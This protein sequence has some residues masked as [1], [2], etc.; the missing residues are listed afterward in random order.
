[1][2]HS[3][4]C[5]SLLGCSFAEKACV[6]RFSSSDSGEKWSQISETEVNQKGASFAGLMAH[7]KNFLCSYRR[8]SLHIFA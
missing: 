8:T 5:R 7:S 1:M 6:N 3:T 4:V 2:N